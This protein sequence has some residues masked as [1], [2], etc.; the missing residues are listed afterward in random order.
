MPCGHSGQDNVPYHKVCTG[1][2]GFVNHYVGIAQRANAALVWDASK[3]LGEHCLR[4]EVKI[5]VPSGKEVVI[6]YGAKHPVTARPAR[7]Q[8]RRLGLGKGAAAI[9][10]LARY[11]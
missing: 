10:A 11:A 2:T 1:V 6:S 8:S 4:L 7:R 9:A 5:L 3:G